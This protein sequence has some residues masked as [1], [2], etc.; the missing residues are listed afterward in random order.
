[1]HLFRSF[2]RWLDLGFRCGNIFICW[3]TLLFS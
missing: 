3:Q 1:M 2:I